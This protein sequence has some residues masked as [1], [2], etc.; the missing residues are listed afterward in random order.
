M[1]LLCIAHEAIHAILT[2]NQRENERETD[3]QTDRQRVTE[4]DKVRIR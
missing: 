3:R 2:L 1:L 4:R